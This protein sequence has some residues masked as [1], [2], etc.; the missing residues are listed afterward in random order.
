MTKKAKI[1]VTIL[2]LV[3]TLSIVSAQSPVISTQQLAQPAEAQA[4]GGSACAAAWGLG[5]A[6]GI[7]ALSPCGVLCASL[8]WYD[9]AAIGA[10][11][12]W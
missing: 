12:G 6:L 1:L 2:T 4:V 11:C 8:A 7:A 3:L 5:L 10:T 9:L